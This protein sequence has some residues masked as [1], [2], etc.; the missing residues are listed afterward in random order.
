M[1]AT[2]SSA[3]TP[4]NAGGLFQR[5]FRDVSRRFSLFGFGDGFERDATAFSGML[6]SMG[7]FVGAVGEARPAAPVLEMKPLYEKVFHRFGGM[8]GDGTCLMRNEFAFPIV[9]GVGISKLEAARFSIQ[10]FRQ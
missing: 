9:H 4:G 1:P 3:R 7:A 10:L 2:D 5:P 6:T 8:P